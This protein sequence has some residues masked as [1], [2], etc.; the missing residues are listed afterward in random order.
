[1]S[2]IERFRAAAARRCGNGLCFCYF[3]TGFVDKRQIQHTDRAL[4]QPLKLIAN[5]LIS[6]GIGYGHEIPGPNAKG[7]TSNEQ[8]RPIQAPMELKKIVAKLFIF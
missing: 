5:E 6:F 2:L 1:M 8:I 7:N 3:G 4:L